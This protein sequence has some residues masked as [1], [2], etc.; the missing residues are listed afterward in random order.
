M[1][2]SGALAN[3]PCNAGAAWTRL[4]WVLG[5]QRLECD[6]YFVESLA[7]PDGRSSEWFQDMVQS[8]AALAMMT[9]V[10]P[11]PPQ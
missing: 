11:V 3:K 4:S 9:V 7:A 5:L 10:P 6:V 1:V 8:L 2:V